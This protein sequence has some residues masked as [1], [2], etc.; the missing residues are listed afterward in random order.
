MG[1]F[2]R[3]LSVPQ[4]FVMALNNV[5][6][7]PTAAQNDV[8]FVEGEMTLNYRVIVQS[9]VRVEPAVSYK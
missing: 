6:G 3:V 5:V 8:V 1:I 2:R 7:E 4:N 9:Y